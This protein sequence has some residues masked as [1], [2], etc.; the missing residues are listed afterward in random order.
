MAGRISAAA[1]SVV[2]VETGKRLAPPPGLTSKERDLWIKIVDEKPADWFRQESVELLKMYCRCSIMLG[3]LGEKI[4][5][6]MDVID[7]AE[8]LEDEKGM[9]DLESM[10]QA[11]LNLTKFQQME[12]KYAQNLMAVATKLRLTPQSQIVPSASGQ[13]RKAPTDKVWE[14]GQGGQ[15]DLYAPLPD[16]GGGVSLPN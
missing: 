9:P 6:V 4:T 7:A 2:Q 11:L 5:A 14:E 13:A 3:W 15:E 12:A 10:G 1:Q 16:D 8:G